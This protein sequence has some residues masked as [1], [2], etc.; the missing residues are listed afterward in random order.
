MWK[1]NLLGLAIT[2]LPPIGLYY[3]AFPIQVLGL[4]LY[5]GGAAIGCYFVQTL[6]PPTEMKVRCLLWLRKSIP[7]PTPLTPMGNA[8]TTILLHQIP[9]RP[10]VDE[11][12]RK[13]KEGKENRYRLRIYSYLVFSIARVDRLSPKSSNPE[14]NELL[15]FMAVGIAS[16]CYQL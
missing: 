4:L 3:S 9:R 14:Q 15:H 7:P 8:F 2:V 16:N 13:V 6:P 10:L 5:L 11:D 12:I 1:A